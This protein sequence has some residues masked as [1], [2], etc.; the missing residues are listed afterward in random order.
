MHE[1]VIGTGHTG[2]DGHELFKDFHL[3]EG[4]VAYQAH[5][6]LG[7]QIIIFKKTK[8]GKFLKELIDR[9]NLDVIKTFLE[10]TIVKHLPLNE[11]K[12]VIARENNNFYRKGKQDKEE[13]IR[14]VL[15]L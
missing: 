14:K 6:F 10:E 11:L 9:R 12:E 4:S 5:S 15:G 7:V 13:E 3:Y 8:E 2:F 1:V